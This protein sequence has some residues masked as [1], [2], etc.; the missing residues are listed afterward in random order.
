MPV[1]LP[2]DVMLSLEY[3]AKAAVRRAAGIKEENKYLFANSSKLMI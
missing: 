2:K 3:I 1:L